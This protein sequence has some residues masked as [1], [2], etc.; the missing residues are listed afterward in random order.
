ML[1]CLFAWILRQLWLR[2]RSVRLYFPFRRSHPLDAGSHVRGEVACSNTGLDPHLTRLIRPSDFSHERTLEANLRGPPPRLGKEA[3]VTL[4]S[5]N[6]RV[7]DRLTLTLE[8]SA[9]A[10]PTAA[11]SHCSFSLLDLTARDGPARS[12]RTDQASAS[13]TAAGRGGYWL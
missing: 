4:P 11:S 2:R 9:V 7:Q 1:P 6:W 12:R 8:A 13:V 5:A 10:P 3:D